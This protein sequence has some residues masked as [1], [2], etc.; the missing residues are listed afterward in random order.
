MY[1][2]L[3]ASAW[4]NRGEPGP[5]I[6]ETMVKAGCR[7]RMSDRSKNSR[8]HGKLEVHK[9][10]ALVEQYVG[11]EIIKKPR[12]IIFN[13]CVNLIRTLPML[14][15]SKTNREDVDTTV[16]DHA[17]DALRYGCMSRPLNPNYVYSN[18]RS[19]KVSPNVYIPV[20]ETFG[21]IE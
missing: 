5:S 17:Y 4:Q 7:W 19:P 15:L 10:L 6:A 13:N 12:L 21:Y 2:V 18:I 3:D 11:G 9:R 16:E 14:P 1:G 20:D 8:V